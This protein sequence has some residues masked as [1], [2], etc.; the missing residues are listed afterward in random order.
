M[1]NSKSTK[2]AS[3]TQT[4]AT[5]AAGKLASFAANNFPTIEKAPATPK[6]GV[7]DPLSAEFAKQRASLKEDVSSLIQDA[8]RPI[9]TS[10]DSLQTTINSFQSRLTSVES[11]A[12]DDFE[13]LT[14]AESAIRMLQS[15]N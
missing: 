15:Q 7:M 1:S 10:L 5:H 14:V 13:R 4:P 9:Q 12:G 11:V 3:N 8:I 6:A 2:S